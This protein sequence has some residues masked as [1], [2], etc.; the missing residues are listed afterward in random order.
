VSITA[1]PLPFHTALLLNTP[2][3]PSSA[4]PIETIFAVLKT[5]NPKPSQSP[6]KA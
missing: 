5:T 4:S 6:Q 2:Q 1:R 3:H